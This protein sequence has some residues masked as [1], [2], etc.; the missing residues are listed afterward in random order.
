MVSF[1]T[2]ARIRTCIVNYGVSKD[3]NGV[4]TAPRSEANTILTENT[5]ERLYEQP[6]AQIASKSQLWSPA[7]PTFGSIRNEWVCKGIKYDPSSEN[8][9][10]ISAHRSSSA[11]EGNL[12]QPLN[13]A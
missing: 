9:A 3:A 2:T 11:H 12:I 4:E 13:S 5:F 1:E 6:K 10:A 7:N 8:T